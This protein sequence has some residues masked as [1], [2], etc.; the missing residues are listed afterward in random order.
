MK[1]PSPAKSSAH[2]APAKTASKRPDRLGTPATGKKINTLETYACNEHHHQATLGGKEAKPRGQT[3][4]IGQKKGQLGKSE[5]I[6][7][8]SKAEIARINHK[9]YV[10]Q[11]PLTK[12]EVAIFQVHGKAPARPASTA[13]AGLLGIMDS[14]PKVKS[15]HAKKAAGKK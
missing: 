2:H 5:P 14:H 4:L 8:P 6:A 12:S 1:R 9:V 11:I 3:V 10:E 7:K 15:Y 13:N